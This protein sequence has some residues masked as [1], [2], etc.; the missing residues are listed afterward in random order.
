MSRRQ[1]TELPT[2]F[3]INAQNIQ[4][5]LLVAYIYGFVL[6]INFQC[7]RNGRG[8]GWWGGRTRHQFSSCS[9]C[10]ICLHH[11]WGQTNMAGRCLPRQNS[12]VI[13]KGTKGAGIMKDKKRKERNVDI[14]VSENLNKIY[15][16]IVVL[17]NMK[18]LYIYNI[19]LLKS[20]IL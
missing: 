5:S 2:Q 7:D 15:L 3:L 4:Y 14:G 19:L 8:R 6:G 9:R 1:S 16:T 11:V 18:K 12:V 17:K 20:Y 10:L 13:T